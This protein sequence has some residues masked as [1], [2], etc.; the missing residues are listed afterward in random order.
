LFGYSDFGTDNTYYYF[1][2]GQPGSTYYF[3]VIAEIQGEAGDEKELLAYKPV[4]IYIPK[5]NSLLTGLA[6]CNPFPF[7]HLS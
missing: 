3:N 1:Q 4:E 5:S 7:I 2:N 6:L